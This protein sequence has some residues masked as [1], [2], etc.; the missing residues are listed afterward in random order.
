MPLGELPAAKRPTGQS[1]VDEVF[2]TRCNCSLTP[3]EAAR[4]RTTGEQTNQPIVAIASIMFVVER[5]I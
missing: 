1:A 2:A 4:L 3:V 5:G